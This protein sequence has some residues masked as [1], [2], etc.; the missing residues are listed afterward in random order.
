MTDRVLAIDGGNSKTAVALVD[1]EGRVLAQV[2]GP[3]ASPQNVG[4]ARSLEVFEGLARAAARQAGLSADQRIATH[5]AAYLAG[6]DLPKEEE[7]LRAAIELRGW[8]ETSV[9]GNDTF[10][11]LRAGTS[12]GIGVAVVCGAGINCVA[13]ARDGR[14]H[15]FP[16][17]GR[18]SGDWGGGAHIGSEALWLAVRAEDGRGAP[19]ALLPALIDH[20][21]T[22]TIAEAVERL[23]FEQVEFDPHVLCPLLFQVAATGDAVAHGVVDRL[24]EEVTL[25][26]SVS[27]Q[28]LGLLDEQVDVVLGGGVLTGTNGVVVDA[29]RDR[30]RDLTPLAQVRVVDVPPV[31]GAAL[32]GLDALG[33]APTA[34]LRLRTAYEPLE[35]AAGG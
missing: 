19:T 32:L 26:A 21:G 9:V 16:A 35:V 4:L 30:L 23:H 10:A 24:V 6:A 29:V 17:L 20:Y 12:D 25:L 34:E 31:V 13:V 22:R 18:I 33:A 14:T 3:G 2:R 15:R 11:L 28:R 27:L 1:V 7:D 5:T 8:S